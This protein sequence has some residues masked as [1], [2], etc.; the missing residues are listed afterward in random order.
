[1]KSIYSVSMKLIYLISILFLFSCQ[2]IKIKHTNVDSTENLVGKIDRID[3]NKFNYL[4]NNKDT[5]VTKSIMFF[6]SKNRIIK[7]IDQYYTSTDKYY[8]FTSEGI[9]IYNDELLESTIA[10]IGNKIVHRTE[11]KYDNKKNLI[12]YRQLKNDTLSF[13]KTTV[14]DKKNNPVEQ[15]YFHPNYKRNNSL[16]KFENDYKNR[17]VTIQGFDENNKIKNSYVKTYFDKKGN[18]I[19]TESIRADSNLNS[20]SKIEFDKS[21]N[22]LRRTTF[23]RDGKA[24]QTREYKNTYDK[25]GNLIIQEIYSKDKL[26]E[27]TTF[28][29]TY[30]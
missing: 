8:T 4:S 9:F 14:Y 20:S 19:K 10:K 25:K 23:D 5:T 11:Y 26:I 7:Q 24:Q 21:G 18:I 22:L 13:L 30:R 12:E 1:M 6:D 29:I 16:E 17:V 15:T 27:K 3:I 2:P 28:Q